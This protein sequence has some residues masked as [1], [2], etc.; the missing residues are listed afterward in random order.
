MTA[1]GTALLAADV[2]AVVEEVF[3]EV[4][5]LQAAAL[6]VVRD[7][8]GAGPG[9]LEDAARELLATPGQLAVGL[10]L[11]VAPRPEDGVGLRLLW[12][13]VDPAGGRL[14]ALHPDLR[15]SSLGFYDYTSTE[16][17]DV[18]RCTG[19][20]HVVGPYVDVHGTGRYLFT[21]TEPVL[22]GG[23]FLGVVGAD[24]PVSRFEASLLGLLGADVSPFVLVNDEGRVVLSTSAARLV[25]ALLRP[26]TDLPGEGTPVAGV[27]WRL[28]PVDGADRLLRG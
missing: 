25:G 9:R 13:Q 15:P 7:L 22:H 8:A 14:V 3:A 2:A 23:R 17:F 4:H 20:R 11:I 19:R 27:P 18:P 21:L 16:W 6:P 10:G 1:T 26:D 24:V 5:R 28:F 12:W